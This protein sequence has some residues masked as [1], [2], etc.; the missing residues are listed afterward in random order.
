MFLSDKMI[1]NTMKSSTSTVQCNNQLEAVFAAA[2]S[3]IFFGAK[4]SRHFSHIPTPACSGRR[5][6][7]T[8]LLSSALA[9]GQS[10]PGRRGKTKPERHHHGACSPKLGWGDDFLTKL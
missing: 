5:C 2:S 9:M 8:T 4:K 1:N 6:V 7:L 3:S 10:V